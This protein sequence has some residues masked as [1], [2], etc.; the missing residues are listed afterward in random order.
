M[1]PLDLGAFAFAV[2]H[3]LAIMTLECPIDLLNEEM[4]ILSKHEYAHPL[5]CHAAVPRPE[6]LLDGFNNLLVVAQLGVEAHIQR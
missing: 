2:G 6:P 4:R 1:S 5:A 3:P